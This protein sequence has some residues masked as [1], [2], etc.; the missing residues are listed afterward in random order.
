MSQIHGIACNADGCGATILWATERG[1][2]APTK[3]GME[4][5]ARDRSWN[6]PDKL[7][8]HWCPAHRR[9]DGRKHRAG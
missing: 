2:K 3:S 9:P 7:G 1:Q 5:K 4:Q 6:A 8:N